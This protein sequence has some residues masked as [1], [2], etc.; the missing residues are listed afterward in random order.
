MVRILP[1]G[2]AAPRVLSPSMKALVNDEDRLIRVKSGLNIVGPAAEKA[3]R[4]SAAAF[5]ALFA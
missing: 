1:V 4:D 2:A 3:G 5:K